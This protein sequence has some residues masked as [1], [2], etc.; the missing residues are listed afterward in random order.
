MAEWNRTS[1]Q[2]SALHH[3][4]NGE[5]FDD[6]TYGMKGEALV[7]LRHLSNMLIESRMKNSDSAAHENLICIKNMQH[8]CRV[9]CYTVNVTDR[10][11]LSARWNQTHSTGV[12]I[13]NLFHNLPVRRKAMKADTERSLIKEFI[14]HMSVLHHNISWTLSECNLSSKTQV[15]STE[16]VLLRLPSQ[17]SVAKRFLHL[18]GVENM[19]NMQE[20]SHTTRGF[21]LQGF[22]TPPLSEYCTKHREGQYLYLN[23]RWLRG[24]DCI[25]NAINSIY[26]R[27]ITAVSGGNLGGM[28][29][30]HASY[31]NLSS[32]SNNINNITTATTAETSMNSS[33][34]AMKQGNTYPYF[35]LHL[36][37]P[38][39]AYDILS[40]PDK[41]VVVFRNE[42]HALQCIEEVCSTSIRQYYRDKVDTLLSLV[43]VNP[44]V[45]AAM[46]STHTT[47]EPSVADTFT[48]T[49][50]TDEEEPILYRSDT[51]LYSINNSSASHYN[52]GSSAPYISSSPTAKATS[53]YTQ[54]MHSPYF[55][56]NSNNDN[57]RVNASTV[58]STTVI[59]VP[60]APTTA[61]SPYSDLF[62]SAF[63]NN[64]HSTPIDDALSPARTL[65]ASNLFRDSPYASMQSTSRTI[66]PKHNVPTTSN[67]HY[68]SPYGSNR[69]N[70][71][72]AHL[73]HS[74]VKR[75]ITSITEPTLHKNAIYNNIVNDGYNCTADIGKGENDGYTSTNKKSKYATIN[76]SSSFDAMFGSSE[77]VLSL[78]IAPT[79]DTSCVID[80]YAE[81]YE[82]ER[83]SEYIS[84][85]VVFTGV[86][87]SYTDEYRTS[88]VENIM[89]DIAYADQ[90]TDAVG[91]SDFHLHSSCHS[92]SDNRVNTV[93]HGVIERPSYSSNETDCGYGS[94]NN[95]QHNDSAEFVT[96]RLATSGYVQHS[97]RDNSIITVTTT[98]A[99]NQSVISKENIAVPTVEPVVVSAVLPTLPTLPA[100]PIRTSHREMSLN[101]AA[102]QARLQC[103]GQ[104]DRRYIVATSCVCDTTDTRITGDSS[105]LRCT[106]CNNTSLLLLLDQH[107]VDERI[108]VEALTQAVA[109]AR[110]D[111]FTTA[112]EGNTSGAQSST[113]YTIV[114]T[115]ESLA[116][117]SRELDVVKAKHQLLKEWGFTYTIHASSLESV[118]NYSTNVGTVNTSIPT[119]QL[120][121][122][123]SIASEPLHASD[124][125]EFLQYITAHSELP[126]SL[127]VPP[128]VSRIVSSRACHSA[129]RFGD[130]LS[131][132]K[133]VSLCQQ[134]MN[135]EL[136]FQCAHGR[137]SMAP[138]LDL[139]GLY[140]YKKQ[141][142]NAA[143]SLR[144]WNL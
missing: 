53:T 94:P 110:A 91:T 13:Y 99:T 135:T 72:A 120:H 136:P 92:S 51:S 138:L 96:S 63:F 121:T 105:G 82:D 124:L 6:S 104:C 87:M 54:D 49:Y 118:C 15:I 69:T 123:P 9:E 46:P 70:M 81:P 114:S 43:P 89:T 36:T 45:R 86:D 50:F 108:Q 137:P 1:K 25:S 74:G 47:T 140:Q 2:N 68:D 126:A 95:A 83:Y 111:F 116:L 57:L 97:L 64:T 7:S 29:A 16:T 4:E 139:R 67:I 32:I 22:M 59:P 113:S 75:M 10:S 133:C 38:T 128:V 66:A 141:E 142:L 122:V 117:S 84:R 41:S 56:S 62:Q 65:S 80:E 55:T 28:V 103:I 88:S 37:C 78:A 35:V 24:N 21:T 134:L 100:L 98:S 18:H 60:A 17:V 34:S 76:N 23:S 19:V 48:D 115:T 39:S 71:S 42:V 119:L 61:Y 30:R 33:S 90:E 3:S 129:V 85:N 77:A 144:T 131:T 79:G 101:K 109:R 26:S 106:K 127:L 112:A 130:A 31:N 8:N 44:I 27:V 132:E 52:S 14:H 40:E 20:I 12:C 5:A 102:L 11:R 58:A 73:Q 125:R 143:M 107:A 93:D